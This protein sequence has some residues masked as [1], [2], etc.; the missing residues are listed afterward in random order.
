MRQSVVGMLSP[1]PVDTP[2]LGA[3]KYTRAV[4]LHI[5]AGATVNRVASLVDVTHKRTTTLIFF[6]GVRRVVC[7]LVARIVCHDVS[8]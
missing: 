7:A 8:P 4:A 6:V 1:Y 5:P 2:K 3:N